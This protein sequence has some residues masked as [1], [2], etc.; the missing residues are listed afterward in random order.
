MK[1]ANL[2]CFVEVVK[3][4]SINKAAEA[5][6]IS[7][8]NVSKTMKALEEEV[9]RKLLIRNNRGITLTKEGELLYTYAKSILAQIEGIELMKET[10]KGETYNS[11]KVSLANIIMEDD[12]MKKYCDFTVAKHVSIKLLETTVEQAIKNVEELESEIGLLVVATK[13]LSNFNKIIELKGLES[14]VLDHSNT[15]IHVKENHPLLQKKDI[16]KKDFGNFPIVKLP[17]DFFDFQCL[18]TEMIYNFFNKKNRIIT[19]NNYHAII[20]TTNYS[21]AYFLGNKWQLNELKKCNIM[22]R[23]LND[24]DYDKTLVWI[25][26]KKEILSEDSL[27]FITMVKQTYDIQK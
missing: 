7:Q 8:P 24:L 19:V 12:M 18:N 9:G 1:I 4:K 17:S 26:R 15:Y 6:Y 20:T 25:K 13:Q 10:P 2:K 3:Q 5:L 23:Q 21:D 11:L 14:F 16:S 27:W 22:S